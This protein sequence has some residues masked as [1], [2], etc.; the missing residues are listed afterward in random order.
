[1]ERCAEIIA[2]YQ[3]LLRGFLKAAPESTAGRAG[4]EILQ[5]AYDLARRA[6]DQ[7]LGVV[8]L[9]AVHHRALEA[10][11]ADK[12]DG[13]GAAAIRSAATLFI[14]SLSPYEMTHRAF[15]ESNAALRSM[16][17]RL[18]QEAKRIAHALHAEAGQLIAY[19]QIAI[20]RLA[21][22]LPQE[23]R[24]RLAE[25][26]DAL[27]RVHDQL[28]QI[29]HELR[30]TILDELGLLPALRFLAEGTSERSGI[31]VT[32][33][34]AFPTRLQPQVETA[35]YR[36][37]QEGLNNI[38]KH[39]NASRATIL[40]SRQPR[41]LECFITDDG[42]GFETER[43]SREVKTGLGL[44]GIRERLDAVGGRLRIVSAPGQGTTLEITVPLEE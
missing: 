25:L 42:R 10:A 5:G 24:A 2:E 31:G 4:E 6:M 20:N 32:V 37:A 1:M 28:R 15:S 19:G 33:K 21:A 27:D 38:V 13:D 39:A 18:E 17:D 9:A 12:G 22:D 41:K 44:L 8:D 23:E 11:L 3:S 16:N 35:L 7:G 29:S 36:V 40:V 14:E 26:R 30:P 43:M 34:G